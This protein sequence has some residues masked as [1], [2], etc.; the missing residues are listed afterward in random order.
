MLNIVLLGAGRVASQLGPALVRAG[1]R[2]PYVWSRTLASAQVLAEALP[3]AEAGTG[4]DL[5]DRRADLYLIAAPDAAVPALLAEA[6]FPTTALV[7]HTSGAVPLAV[8]APYAGLRGGVFYP[9]QTFSL[10][11]QVNW[12]T[13]PLCIEAADAAAEAMLLGLAHEL[14]QQVARVATP[15]RQALH[16]AAVFA[17]NFPNHLLGISHTLLTEAGLSFALLEPLVR[18]TIDKAFQHPP[19]TVQTGPAARHDE[20]TLVRHQAAL[21]EHPEWLQLYKSL[22]DSVKAQTVATAPNNQGDVQL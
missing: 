6:R 5:S 12:Q 4:L 9:L 10:E 13:V 15:Q 7:A 2:V 21:A 8:F 22:T 20:P 14:S 1:H 18:E 16:V 3:G 19:F 17:C 11:R